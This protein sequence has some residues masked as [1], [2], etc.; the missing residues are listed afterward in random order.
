MCKHPLDGQNVA[1]GTTHRKNGMCHD[2]KLENLLILE[3]MK[4]Y[5]L[6]VEA[7]FLTDATSTTTVANFPSTKDVLTSLS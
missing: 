3:L 2:E 4:A 7:P 5:S 6:I 1:S